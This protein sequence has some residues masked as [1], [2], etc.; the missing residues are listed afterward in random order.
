[1]I[2]DS[3]TRLIPGAVGN[4]DSTVN[5]SFS[6]SRA[7]ATEEELPGMSA[8]TSTGAT[9]L[10]IL[11]YPHYTRPP[12]F[13]GWDVPDVLLSGNHEDIRRWRE[14]RALEKRAATAPICLPERVPRHIS[15]SQKP[16]FSVEFE[17][18]C[19]S[20]PHLSGSA[21]KIES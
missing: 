7:A 17:F 3:V 8:S 5:E 12:S 16:P 15:A 20:W 6:A 11:D 4:A 1:M 9:N 21:W 2:L 10:G 14:A 19:R 13:R 18:V